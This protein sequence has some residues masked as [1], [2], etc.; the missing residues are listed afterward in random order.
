MPIPV[1]WPAALDYGGENPW[2]EQ[3]DYNGPTDSRLGFNQGSLLARGERKVIQSRT[4]PA[5]MELCEQKSDVLDEFE[6]RC[7]MGIFGHY[8]AKYIWRRS[9]CHSPSDEAFKAFLN[10]AVTL[11]TPLEK[12]QQ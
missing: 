5:R 12:Y 1:P 11:Y 2:R 9:H 4:R 10:S 6:W 3:P 7:R 8:L